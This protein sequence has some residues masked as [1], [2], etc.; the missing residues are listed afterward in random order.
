MKLKNKS[1]WFSRLESAIWNSNNFQIYK[2]SLI[3]M[4]IKSGYKNEEKT[5]FYY[6][7]YSEASILYFF[8]IAYNFLQFFKFSTPSENVEFHIHQSCMEIGLSEVVKCCSRKKWLKEYTSCKI[9]LCKITNLVL[10][11]YNKPFL[12]KCE[13]DPLGH[14]WSSKIPDNWSFK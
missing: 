7:L 9:S 13:L 11:C 14:S 10:G 8:H 5:T 1:I 6:L 4:F 3:D 12:K 2:R